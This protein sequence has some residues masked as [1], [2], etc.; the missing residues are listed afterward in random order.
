MNL[1]DMIREFA[2]TYKEWHYLAGGFALGW[3]L[4]ILVGLK[5]Q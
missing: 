5:L 3:T 2:N 4:G 1:G